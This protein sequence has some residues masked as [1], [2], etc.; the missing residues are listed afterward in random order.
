MNIDIVRVRDLLGYISNTLRLL[1]ELGALTESDF[2]ADYRNIT[3]AKY[4]LI[5]VIEAAIDLCNHLVARLGGRAPQDYADCFAVL[6]ELRVIE[7]DLA[8]RLKQMARFRNLLVHL[9]QRVDDRRVYRIIQDHLGD[10]DL[11]RQQI[12]TW[13]ALRNGASSARGGLDS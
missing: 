7:A 12:A 9:Y 10:L 1:R 5:V 4:L 3:S 2:L 8:E 6:A 11:F 13:L